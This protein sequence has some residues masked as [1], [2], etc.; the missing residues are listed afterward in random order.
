MFDRWRRRA[1]GGQRGVTAFLLFAVGAAPPLASAD[2]PTYTAQFL[3]PGLSAISAAAMN[4][5]GDVVG[6]S[7]TGSGGWVSYVG[8]PAVLLPPPPGA[9]Y[10]FASDINDAGVIVGAA[11]PTAYP[12]Y[13]GTAVAWIPDGSGGYT[14]QQ[15][16]TLPGHVT[17]FATA[18]NNVGDVIGY[19]SNG[20]FRYP[21]LFSAPG[22]IQDLSATGVFDPA[23]INDQRVLVDH[24]FTCKRLDLNSMIV[25]DLGVP[26]GPPTYQASTGAA[27]NEAGQVAG[28]AI[29]AC[30][31]NCDRV[32]ARYTEEVGWEIFSG[33]GQSNGAGSINDLGDVVMRLNVAPYVRLEGLGTFLIEDLIVADVGHWYVINGS[34]PINNARQMAIPAT[35]SVTNQTGIVLLTPVGLLVGDLN[36]DGAVDFGDINPFVLILADP[37]AWQAAYPS[38]PAANGDV[39]GDGSVGFGDIN[40]FVALLA[41]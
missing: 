17:S 40:P 29:Y 15:F 7:T 35:N 38:C 34:G 14:I 28:L 12:E 30:C 37:A 22:G 41:G 5:A 11:G 24:S 3:T 32:A 31:P 39:N 27:I 36:C 18:V 23:D 13:G 20:T 19:S 1:C 33:C 2:P 10:T 16:G 21:V 26:A 4:E 8:A 6:T 9:Q 25:E